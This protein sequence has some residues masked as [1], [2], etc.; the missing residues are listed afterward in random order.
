MPRLLPYPQIADLVKNRTSRIA[1]AQPK[2]SKIAEL[3]AKR[4]ALAAD[5]DTALARYRR[6][7]R[8]A[9][10]AWDR[11]AVW[12]VALDTEIMDE[13]SAELGDFRIK[14]LLLK[15]LADEDGGQRMARESEAF[16]DQVL[17]WFA[18]HP[19]TAKAA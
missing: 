9:Y 3:W 19:E 17:E 18:A 6:G 10:D 14:A 11:L 4:M 16:V 2:R 15:T 7:D 8:G 13:A 12:V 1:P 5:R